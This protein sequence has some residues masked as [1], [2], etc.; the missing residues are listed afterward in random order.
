M[1]KKNFKGLSLRKKT[2]TN[3]TQVKGGVFVESKF[4]SD[5]TVGTDGSINACNSG[6]VGCV[7]FTCP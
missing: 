5:P 4:I 7:S 1:K 6:K 3:L 2:I